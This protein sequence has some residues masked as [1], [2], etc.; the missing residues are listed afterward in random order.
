MKTFARRLASP[1]ARASSQRGFILIAALAVL[2]MLTMLSVSMFHSL[3][4]EE[5]ITGNTRE[6]QHAFFAAQSALQSAEYWL[7]SN[8][9]TGTACSMTSPTPSAQICTLATTP[10]A[11]SLATT[12]WNCSFGST[13]VPP[14]ITV[15]GTLTQQLIPET[16]CAGTTSQGTVYMDPQ[17][18]ITYLGADPAS[19]GAYLYQV[20]SL[21]Y[22]GNQNAV[23]VVQSVFSVG[24]GGAQQVNK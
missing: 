15:N 21:G 19:T 1:P 22:G 12:L 5:R 8:A 2:L 7:Q 3:G 17:F 24:G 4:L 11:Q 16:N 6:K 13:Y 10:S 20:T 14:S 9:G 23:A 18:A